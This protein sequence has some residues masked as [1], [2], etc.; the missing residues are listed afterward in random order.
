MKGWWFVR[1]E[2][3]QNAQQ[4]WIDLNIIVYGWQFGIAVGIQKC[5]IP[6][7]SLLKVGPQFATTCCFGNI[8]S[9]KYS[10]EPY[11]SNVISIPFEC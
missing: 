7:P 9:R 1:K 2:A 6:S 10:Y 5:H 8:C 3:I 4:Q 11:C